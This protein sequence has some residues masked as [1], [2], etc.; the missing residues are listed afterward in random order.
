NASCTASSAMSKSPKARIRL[1]TDRPDSSRKIRPTSTSSSLGVAWTS[2][3]PSGLGC[4]ERT[5]LDWLPDDGGGLRR[6]SERSV[7]VPGL[8]DVETAEMFL[9]FREGAVGGQHLAV[10]HPNDGGRFGFVQGAA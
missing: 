5:D 7:A 4:P 1:A 2:G 10:G 8:D 3:T 6:P 9:R